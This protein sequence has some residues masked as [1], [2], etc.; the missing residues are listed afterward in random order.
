MTHVRLD[1]VRLDR[2]RLDGLRPDADGAVVVRMRGQASSIRRRS[3]IRGPV[4]RGRVRLGA[5]RDGAVDGVLGGTRRGLQNN[6][7]CPGKSGT[8][9]PSNAGCA[10]PS[11]VGRRDPGHDTSS[12]F[13]RAPGGSCRANRPATT[14][15]SRRHSGQLLRGVT[16]GSVCP[17][18]DSGTRKPLC[19]T[20]P[21][22]GGVSSSLRRR[23][24]NLG[25]LSRQICRVIDRHTSGRSSRRGR[26]GL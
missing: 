1:R 3:D 22:I 11:C 24:W 8:T 12:P 13:C 9:Y 17:G 7:S 5:A 23:D 19:S 18:R 26:L 6:G 16:M 21:Q 14:A 25:R 20:F 15:I 10:A 2:V 4:R